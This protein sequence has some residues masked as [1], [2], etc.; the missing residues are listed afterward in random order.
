[1]IRRFLEHRQKRRHH[2]YVWRWVDS[3]YL[4]NLAYLFPEEYRNGGFRDL[5]ERVRRILIDVATVEQATAIIKLC[6]E[7][8][9]LREGDA[10]EKN[11]ADS[12][13]KRLV[14]IYGKVRQR[15][16]QEISSRIETL[17]HHMDNDILHMESVKSSSDVQKARDRLKAL[18]DEHPSYKM[19]RLRMNT[20]LN[21]IEGLQGKERQV[22]LAQ[23][24]DKI[25]SHTK[26]LSSFSGDSFQH[27]INAS[28]IRDLL[29]TV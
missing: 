28:V 23:V 10:K 3:I 9:P 17:L 11:L 22:L 20:I 7:I 29:K 4:P 16:L 27:E 21:A 12:L 8:L 1:M 2:D 15:K 14:V 19:R 18:G 6:D 24:N 13:K 25:D 5:R 26:E